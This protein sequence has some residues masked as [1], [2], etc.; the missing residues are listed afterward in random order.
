MPNN[1]IHM[2]ILRYITLPY[3]SLIFLFHAKICKICIDIIFSNVI[4]LECPVGAC[5][6]HQLSHQAIA[7]VLLNQL[8]KILINLT[9]YSSSQDSYYEDIKH[10]IMKS[11]LFYLV[12]TKFFNMF[13]YILVPIPSI[14][15]HK[16]VNTL[17]TRKYCVK[18]I[19]CPILLLIR[20]TNQIYWAISPINTMQYKCM[21]NVLILLFPCQLTFSYSPYSG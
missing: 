10:N 21:L 16:V 12:K 5:S 20:E 18:A 13:M 7:I 11:I 4:H 8:L 14:Y 2:K 15:L 3:F 9:E 1:C 6:S 17:G 19:I